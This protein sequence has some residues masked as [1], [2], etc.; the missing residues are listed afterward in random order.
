LV[1][2]VHKEKISLHLDNALPAKAE[3]G[4]ITFGQRLMSVRGPAPI[5]LDQRLH[6][7]QNFVTKPDLRRPTFFS[8]PAGRGRGF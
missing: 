4:F 3:I 8:L 6:L 2:F 7:S 5:G 1:L